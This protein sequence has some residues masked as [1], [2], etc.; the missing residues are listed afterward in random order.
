KGFDALDPASY[1]QYFLD[2]RNK[3]KE[4]LNAEID[5]H[6]EGKDTV[7]IEFI[8]NYSV[9]IFLLLIVLAFVLL[10]T[11]FKP[12][13]RK[14]AKKEKNYLKNRLPGLNF[15]PM[16][17]KR[18][19]KNIS[20]PG[21]FIYYQ[22]PQISAM[23]YN[24]SICKT[25]DTDGVSVIIDESVPMGATLKLVIVREKT[26]KRNL[27]KEHIHLNADVKSVKE[28]PVKDTYELYL[29]FHHLFLSQRAFISKILT[30]EKNK[31]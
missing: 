6:T 8:K 14:V 1:K 7:N 21:V 2:K 25:I 26:I 31:T 30:Q 16:K 19:F 9:E 4:I 24:E 27:I 10:L 11:L 28:G 3:L 18:S 23:Q 17:D 22:I 12:K 20:V 5:K 29:V 15:I 13:K